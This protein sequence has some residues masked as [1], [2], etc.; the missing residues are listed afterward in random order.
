MARGRS[1]LSPHVA[2]G[3]QVDRP[4]IALIGAQV[5]AIVMQERHIRSNRNYVQLSLERT[6]PRRKQVL[7]RET[8]MIES[9]HHALRT[10]LK[11]RTTPGRMPATNAKNA[12]EQCCG[13][14][15]QR[16]L[17]LSQF[18]WRTFISVSYHQKLTL[19]PTEQ[20]R[21]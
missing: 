10:M 17:L 4:G 16:M 14:R 21:T 9:Q 6:W 13:I 8:A 19:M 12:S 15:M 7:L 18:M 20:L 3:I 1:W 5:Q 2:T 11:G